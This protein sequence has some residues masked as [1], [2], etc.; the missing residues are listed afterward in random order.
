MRLAQLNTGTKILA[1]FGI[2]ALV[3]I[4]IS[5]V[6]LWR[7]EAADRL[8]SDLVDD[9]LAKQ[10]LVSDLLG[11]ERLNG[12]RTVS[13][14]RSDSL[15]LADYFQAQLAEGG[16]AAAAIEAKLGK[17][18]ATEQE[19]ALLQA[20]AKHKA[21]LAATQAE[22]FK[23]KEFGQTQVVEQLVSGR[24]E[25][26]YKAQVAAL[27]ALLRH[28]SGEAHRL[29]DESATA[30]AFSKSLLAVLCLGAL[31]VGGALAFVLTRN[32]VGP[33][34]QAAGLAE[35][36]ARGDLRPVI[37]HARGDEIGRLFDALNGMTQGVSSTVS[38][39]LQGAQAIDSASS[40]IADGNQD[41]SQRTE[42]QATALRQTVGAMEELNEAISRNNASARQANTLAQSAS[43]VAIEGA[44]AVEQL[45]A[46]M[47]AIKASAE[48][49]VDITGMI[50]SIAFQ[51]NILALNAAVEAARAGSEGRGFAVVAAEV[52]N[53]AQHSAGA[54]K[55]IKK[56]IGESAGE[57]EAG[58]GMAEQAGATMR[59]VLEHV[60]QVAAILGTIHEASTG[61]ASGVEQ[62]T[63][64]IAEMDLSTQQNAAMVEEAAAA[65]ASMRQQ[66]AELSALVGTFK[67]RGAN[68]RRALE[69]A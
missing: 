12:S 58:T 7:M 30:S 23:A 17:L 2:V 42:R 50:D 61:Q 64:A 59:A 69:A 48:R 53:L 25:Q 60:H 8:T 13:I 45:V 14:A 32:I 43:G 19:R 16:K 37:R 5:A 62:V 47:G 46:R 11:I 56:L 15:E 57:I 3:I 67:L 10:Q 65:A 40:E 39:V 44:Q 51:T 22:L 34:Q 1:S 27:E 24:W 28:E 41:L 52:R 29:A 31:A 38:Q 35:Q 20:A 4:L 55:E 33:L 26:G 9:K 49:I 18:P 54:A 66:A 68:G 63:R 6:A 21:A 36:V